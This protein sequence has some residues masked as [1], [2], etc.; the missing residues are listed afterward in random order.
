MVLLTMLFALVPASLSQTSVSK[1]EDGLE[2][3]DVG[4]N[5]SCAHV[6]R[7]RQTSSRTSENKIEAFCPLLREK[8]S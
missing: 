1:G 7:G 3:G 8:P 5:V 2:V 4:E 6:K